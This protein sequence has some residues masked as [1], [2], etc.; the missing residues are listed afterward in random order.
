VELKRARE[1]AGLAIDGVAYKLKLLPRQIESLE[2]ERF[3]RLPG[4]AIAR[5]MVRSYARLLKLDPEP[6]VERMAA[7]E[8]KATDRGQ[9]A[10]RHREPLPGRNRRSTLLY[11]GFSL[12]LLALIGALVYEWRQEKAA[13]EI[14][15]PVE[16]PQVQPAAVTQVVP[17]VVPE[18]PPAAGEKPL[19][20]PVERPVA[21]PVET[22]VAK[23]VETPPA[24]EKSQVAKAADKPKPQ[25]AAQPTLPPGS[26]HLVLRMEEEAWLEVRDGAGRSL[27]A[28]LNPAGTERALRGQPPFELVVGNAA[29]VKLTYDGKP[30]DLKPHI[31][32]EVARFTLQ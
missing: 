9:V 8:E 30:V 18:A 29:H 27:V 32:G 3:D 21:K 16:P 13:P 11:A 1:A 12:V 26:H 14:A 28:S 22:P 7:R 15:A 10:G 17:P 2:H 19:A 25:T 24:S 23:P 4:P 20:E 6:L 5:R 31:R